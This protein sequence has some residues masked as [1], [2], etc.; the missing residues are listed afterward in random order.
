MLIPALFVSIAIQKRIATGRSIHKRNTEDFSNRILNVKVVMIIHSLQP[1]C[2]PKYLLKIKVV[3]SHIAYEK[4]N[5]KN[6]PDSFIKLR[7]QMTS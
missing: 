3:F 7:N 2:I 4:C 5:R 1:I 6:N